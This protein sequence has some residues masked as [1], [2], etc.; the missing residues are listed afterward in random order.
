V[1]LALFG[2]VLSDGREI[3]RCRVTVDGATIVSVEAG[4]APAPGDV[5][6][7]DGWIAPG[8][9]DLHIHG[10][11][12]ADLTCDAPTAA[13][14]SVARILARR[15]V[16]SFCPTVSSARAAVY[17]KAIAAYAPRAHDAAAESLGANLEGPFIDPERRGFQDP[18]V[19]RPASGDEMRQWI[20]AGP[21][22]IVT[23]APEMAG[24]LEAVRALV[25]AGTVVS[26]GHSGATAE[27]VRAALAAGARHATHLFNAMPPLHHREPGPA[28]ALLTSSAT[29]EVIA[30]GIHLDPIVVDLVVRAAGPDRVCL[31]TDAL[32]ALGEPPGKTRLGDREVIS[33]GK[34]VRHGDGTLAGTAVSLDECL[35]N[36]RRWLPWL[37]PAQVVKMA[38]ST[39]A[40]VLGPKVAARKGRIAP[41]FDA[42]AILLDREWNVVRTYVRGVAVR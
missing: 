18:A 37:A 31:V 26:I 41:G 39:P 22:A 1:T 5:V 28:G 23:L 13:V 34:A 14:A 32:A 21:P 38:T 40:S 8:L 20:A 30:D 15:G 4:A 25:A 35:R 19:I 29:L 6:H 7:G 3:E 24:G 36:A 16:T 10:A 42:D 27:Q 11:G 33:D 9:V 12:G 2:T 17:A